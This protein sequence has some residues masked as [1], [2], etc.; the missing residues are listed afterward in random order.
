MRISLS[1][2]Y[3]SL[4]VGYLINYVFLFNLRAIELLI[5]IDETIEDDYDYTNSEDLYI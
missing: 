1:S 3:N 5:S 2:M 4:T